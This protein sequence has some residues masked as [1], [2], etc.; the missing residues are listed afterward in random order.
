MQWWYWYKSRV[1]K[2]NKDIDADT[3]TGLSMQTVYR[4]V[5]MQVGWQVNRSRER[6]RDH[7]LVCVTS[8]DWGLNPFFWYHSLVHPYLIKTALQCHRE[9]S[10]LHTCPTG[11]RHKVLLVVE[12]LGHLLYVCTVLRFKSSAA[13]E[14]P[15]VT[16]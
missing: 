3:D 8:W 14:G 6:T 11:P 13:Q 4:S 2:C 1:L 9:K 5:H 7:I 15:T 12:F 16:V 10:P